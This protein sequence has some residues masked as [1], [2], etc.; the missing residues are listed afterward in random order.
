LI[1]KIKSPRGTPAL[2]AQRSA[3][4]PSGPFL[5]PPYSPDLSPIKECWSNIKTILRTKA[6]RTLER[7]W[8]AITAAVGALHSPE[9]PRFMRHTS[10]FS[11]R[12]F[13]DWCGYEPCVS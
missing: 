5:L 9:N 4:A 8:Q 2:G 3:K 11:L 1:G 12:Q 13:P 6:G 7:L 10:S